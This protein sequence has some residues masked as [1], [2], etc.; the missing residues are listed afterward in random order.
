MEIGDVILGIAEDEIYW[1]EHC[2]KNL[3]GIVVDFDSDDDI[4]VEWIN[5]SRDVAIVPYEPRLINLY[6]SF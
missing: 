5:L 3:I 2:G 6:C 1:Y 4:S